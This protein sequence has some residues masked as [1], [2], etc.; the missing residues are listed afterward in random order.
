MLSTHYYYY[1]CKCKNI[2]ANKVGKI[3]DLPPEFRNFLLLGPLVVRLEV[4]YFNVK[5]LQ[6]RNSCSLFLRGF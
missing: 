1:C 3:M 5:G 4:I 2:Q 6:Q